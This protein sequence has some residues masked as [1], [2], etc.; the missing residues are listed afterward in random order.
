ML[1]K[2]F[3]CDL[4]KL[5]IL[6]ILTEVFYLCYP[7]LI[8]Y[9]IDY[10]Q[11]HRDNVNYGI[12]LFTI[13]IVI[14]FLYNLTYTNLKYLFKILGVNISTHLNL[15]IY[16]KSLKL[17]LSSNKKFAESDIIS[18]S[19]IDTDNMMYIGSKLAYFIFGLIEIFAGFALLYWF[20][21]F[22]F[23]AGLI[24][25]VVIS[26]VTFIISSCNVHLGEEVLEKK[27]Q[28]LSATE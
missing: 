5:V 1:L 17:S 2:V 6:C 27:D 10:L 22:S 7:I 23:V 3:G 26:V 8:Y 20:V 4:V 14:S 21:G 28:R 19:Q 12:V 18:Y 15:L 25:L 9:N 24:V 16:H 13:T 11:N